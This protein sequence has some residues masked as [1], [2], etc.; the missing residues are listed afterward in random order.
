[1]ILE[2]RI[3]FPKFK[4]DI[5]S[6]ETKLESKVKA[7]RNHLRKL[8]EESPKH[9]G[10]KRMIW[11]NFSGNHTCSASKKTTE[12]DSGDHHGSLGQEDVDRIYELAWGGLDKAE[13]L[14]SMFKTSPAKALDN[15][16]MLARN[17][18][19]KFHEQQDKLRDLVSRLKKDRPDD[20]IFFR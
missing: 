17:H 4:I 6:N 3:Y 15:H 11:L 9:L 13:Q 7:T 2:E 10:G 16:L 1:M 19:L 20:L 12:S 5:H 14:R 18:I 8:K